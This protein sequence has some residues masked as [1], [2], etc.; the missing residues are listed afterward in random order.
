MTEPA[1]ESI[2]GT[3]SAAEV[4]VAIEYPLEVM[5][6]IRA[7]ATEGFQKLA[8]G[9]LE[10]AGVLFGARREAGIRILTWRPIYC[11]YALGPTLQLS[12]RDQAELTRLLQ[13][14]AKDP[15]LEGLQPVGWF[16]SHTRSD[17]LLSPQ[18]L[19]IFDRF[20]PEPWQVTLVLRPTQAGPARAGFFVRGADGALKSD[21]S[22][23]EF[24]VKPLHR[25][26]NLA[27]NPA[28]VAK[29]RS[30][31]RLK[32]Q[33]ALATPVAAAPIA[34]L[35]ETRPLAHVEPPVFRTL[36]RTKAPRGWLWT[37]PVI[38]GI[39]VAGFLVKERYL[40]IQNQTFFFHVQE[41]GDS[42]RIEWDQNAAA[43]RNA[44]VGAIDVKDGGGT[45]RYALGDQ[46]LQSGQ[47]L[48]KRQ[49]GDLEIRMTVYPVGF[50]PVQQ[51]AHF[52]D[53]GSGVPASSTPTGPPAEVEQL[54]QERDRLE[55]E[56]KQLKEN[57]RKEQAL[58]RRRR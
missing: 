15:D 45:K 31:S 19:D 5:D 25:G 22:Y 6:E 12:D 30:N 42:V 24:T 18:D 27:D 58:R 8:R 57:L 23:Q 16:L 40:T 41:A 7:T 38:L 39:I 28:P 46:E 37:L 10:V 26:Y 36:D 1:A 21:S 32:P 2:F 56:V 17:I 53:P 35:A 48:Y 43:I 54:R 4:P 47:M 51:F 14:S 33:P 44:H 3:W 9:G 29:E 49:G 50:N 55:T 11:E 52:L 13:T 20:F 34:T